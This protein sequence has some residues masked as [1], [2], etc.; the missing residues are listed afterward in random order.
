MTTV[1]IVVA[2]IPLIF[3]GDAAGL[4]IVRPMA[5]VILG[6]V[7]TAALLNLYVLPSLYLR[8]GFVEADTSTD[9]LFV[10]IPEAE[11]EAPPRVAEGTTMGEVR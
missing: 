6:G 5:I 11:V 10:T 3:A 4:E 9:D 2:M 8:H 7:I 1:A